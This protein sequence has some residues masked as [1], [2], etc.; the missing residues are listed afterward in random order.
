V[1]VYNTDSALVAGTIEGVFKTTD[2]GN[3]WISDFTGGNNYALYKIARTPDNTLF[4]SGSQGMI[5]RKKANTLTANFSSLSDTICTGQYLPFTDLSTGNVTSRL[6][7]FPGGNPSSSTLQYPVV[8]Y[9]TAGNWDVSLTVWDGTNSNTLLQPAF[10]KVITL[11]TPVISGAQVIPQY[12]IDT[13]SVVYHPGNYYFWNMHGGTFISG[14]T[15]HEVIVQWGPAG[16]SPAYL[17]VE[18]YAPS[19]YLRDSLVIIIDNP[20]A[21]P[22][23]AKQES[24]IYPEPAQDKLNISSLQDIESVGIFDLTGRKM[25][26]L[27]AEAKREMMIDVSGLDNG[28][29]LLQTISISGSQCSRVIHIL[30]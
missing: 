3:T 28:T 5:L 25:M 13:H 18:E 1:H 15:N 17:T 19:C 14:Y 8:Q 27:R 6:W 2:G 20:S 30:R 11:D 29:Y 12:T 7:S 21:I 16:T 23:H 4:I 10:V 26:S 22:E 24:R 9:S